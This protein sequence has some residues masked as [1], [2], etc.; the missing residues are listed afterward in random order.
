MEI[1]EGFLRDSCRFLRITSDLQGFLTG[2][3][4]NPEDPGR[5]CSDFSGIPEVSGRFRDSG[6]IPHGCL[7]DSSGIILYSFGIS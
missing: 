4:G 7:R 3:E 5:V 2:P 1:P 6:G